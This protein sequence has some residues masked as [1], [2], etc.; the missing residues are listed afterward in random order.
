M[1]DELFQWTSRSPQ[2]FAERKKRR[3]SLE[4]EGTK[5]PAETKRLRGQ[6][7][8]TDNWEEDFEFE[9]GKVQRVDTTTSL[10]RYRD[11][12][13]TEDYTDDYILDDESLFEDASDLA[14]GSSDTSPTEFSM[15]DVSNVYTS[16]FP[17]PSAAL[18][19]VHGL[20][21][22]S[23]AETQPILEDDEKADLLAYINA[24]DDE[25]EDSRLEIPAGRYPRWRSPGPSPLFQE[26]HVNEPAPNV[27]CVLDVLRERYRRDEDESGFPV[28]V[29]RRYPQ[30]FFDDTE[31]ELPLRPQDPARR[32]RPI[33]RDHEE[34]D[35]VSLRTKLH[36]KRACY[37]LSELPENLEQY[38]GPGLYRQFLQRRINDFFYEGIPDLS[39][40]DIKDPPSFG[41]PAKGPHGHI[42]FTQKK[43]EYEF[44]EMDEITS[45]DRLDYAEAAEDMELGLTPE[46][47]L[48]VTFSRPRESKESIRTGEEE[49]QDWIFERKW[50]YPDAR[51][52]AFW[53]KNKPG[54][55][56]RK[57]GRASSGAF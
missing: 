7:E 35:A 41:T 47:K 27:R 55:K 56:R 14:E 20:C 42:T 15:T 2:Y 28:P 12:V 50:V 11:E 36:V 51:A 39:D 53:M 17:T 34:V 54:R 37:W 52:I 8:A 22:L 43:Y 57:R 46:M 16:A 21:G 48:L 13:S 1:A 10:S 23:N 5:E 4:G 24:E 40:D 31:D 18:S 45:M 44:V 38:E 30:L 33:A 25:S 3:R 6:S 29:R 26:Y 49:V 9:T 19:G 32:I